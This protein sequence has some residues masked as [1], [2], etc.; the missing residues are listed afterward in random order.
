MSHSRNCG[1]LYGAYVSGHAFV[2]TVVEAK[3]KG[4]NHISTFKVCSHHISQNSTDQRRLHGIGKYTVFTSQQ[5]LQHHV[6]KPG[7]V[8]FYYKDSE[9][10]V[11][12]IQSTCL[13]VFYLSVD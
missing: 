8:S 5:E 1:Y 6:A 11:I 4:P 2:L 9:E 3:G 12:I 13:G 7:D 10:L